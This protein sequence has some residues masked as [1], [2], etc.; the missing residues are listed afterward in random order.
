MKK[1]V[2][3]VLVVALVL[4]IMI[5]ITTANPNKV[6]IDVKA[7]SSKDTMVLKNELKEIERERS[8]LSKERSD[9]YE[10][11]APIY[12]KTRQTKCSG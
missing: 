8:K 2:T 10:D 1:I 11:S 12:P 7:I 3:I 9:K 5:S 6:Y 4:G